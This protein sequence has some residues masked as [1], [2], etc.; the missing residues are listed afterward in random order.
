METVETGLKAFALTRFESK[1][2]VSIAFFVDGDNGD[3]KGLLSPLSPSH[4]SPMETGH[5]KLKLL[6]ESVLALVSTVSTI[7]IKKTHF[8][9]KAVNLNF[10]AGLQFAKVFLGIYLLSLL[11]R[12]FLPVGFNLLSENVNLSL[13]NSLDSTDLVMM[14]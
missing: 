12:L 14:A 5:E 1:P 11:V 7:S 8:G 4:F 13:S 2:A 10:E 3:R 9:D 6:P